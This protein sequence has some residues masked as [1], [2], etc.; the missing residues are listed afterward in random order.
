MAGRGKDDVLAQE[1]GSLTGRAASL[2]VAKGFAFAL[3][4]ALPLLLVRRLSVEEFGAYKQ[5]FLVVGSALVV[6]PLGFG[7]SAFYFLPRERDPERRAQVVLNVVLFMLAT[8]GL[9]AAAFVARPTLLANLFDDASLAAYAPL[10][11]LVVLL[12]VVGSFLEF[13]T[14][15]NGE[16]RL[17]TLFIVASQLTKTALLLAAALAYGTVRSLVWAAAAQGAVQT[18]VLLVY[19]RSRF[20]RFWRRFS[21][22]LARAQLAY[23]LPFGVAAVVLQVQLDLPQYFVSRAFGAAVYAVYAVGCFNLPIVTILAESAGS[24]MIPRV[25][26][27]QA[28]GQRREIAEAIARM[29]RKLAAGY[30]GIFAFLL[31]FGREFIE[32]LF[33]D[34]YLGAWPVFAVNLLLIPLGLLTSGCD[35]VLRAYAEYRYFFLRVRVAVVVALFAA[36]WLWTGRLGP[37]GTIGIVVVANA[38]ERL[39]TTSKVWRILGLGARDVALFAGVGRLAVAA[40][41]AGLVAAVARAGVAGAPPVVLLASGAVVF[42]IVYA[43]AIALA[44]VPTRQEYASLHEHAARLRRL[45]SR[46]AAER[47]A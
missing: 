41:A 3:A 11:G 22:S 6:V 1:A 10:V 20:G 5:I 43:A 12:W 30:F 39:A 24:V 47:S 35:P 28:L 45:I 46:T 31:V 27:M 23:A 34:R 44:N 19:L 17:A 8:S 29:M 33:T 2:F 7:M 18:V 36:L 13:A 14:L 37:V 25:S 21:W 15:A 42:G 4:F 9:V 16:S 40:A 26:E 38:V 32:L